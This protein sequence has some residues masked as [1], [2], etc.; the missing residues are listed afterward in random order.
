MVEILG[1]DIKILEDKVPFKYLGEELI[2]DL[3]AGGGGEI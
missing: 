3:G 1:A 2:L